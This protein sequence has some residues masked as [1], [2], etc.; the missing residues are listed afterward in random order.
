MKNKEKIGNYL[1]NHDSIVKAITTFKMSDV[2]TLEQGNFF[3]WI[4]RYIKGNYAE[5]L[6]YF[7]SLDEALIC[8]NSNVSYLN[9]DKTRFKYNVV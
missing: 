8:F 2:I 3:Y 4:R 6:G 5:L 9:K 7:T 1:I